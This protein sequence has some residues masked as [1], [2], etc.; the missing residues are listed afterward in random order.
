MKP[1]R[2]GR[3]TAFHILYRYDLA[4]MNEGK[5]P[6]QEAEL[7]TDLLHHFEHFEVDGEAK[8]FAD[9]L[10]RGVLENQGKVDQAIHEA[11][12]KWKISRMDAVDRSL[13]RLAVFELLF[14]KDIPGEV[15]LD[16]AIELAKQF[17][18]KD[19]PSFVNG[20]LD[21]VLKKQSPTS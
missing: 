8:D 2:K 18:G 11:S 21:A 5:A 14:L 12:T 19:S 3:E 10:V 13:L 17:G 15:S 6:P 7:F 16:E 9:Q 20:V 4:Q 1:R